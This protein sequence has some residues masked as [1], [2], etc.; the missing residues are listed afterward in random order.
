M[1]RMR[2]NSLIWATFVCSVHVALVVLSETS[3]G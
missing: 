2:V 3:V 1:D